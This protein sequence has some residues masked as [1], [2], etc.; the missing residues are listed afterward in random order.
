MGA[1]SL[2]ALQEKDPRKKTAIYLLGKTGMIERSKQRVTSLSQEQEVA[3]MEKGWKFWDYILSLIGRGDAKELSKFVA[4]PER[5]IMNRI[6]TVISCSDQVP[7]WLKT[8][9]GKPLM[10]KRLLDQAAQAKKGR[11]SRKMLSSAVKKGEEAEQDQEAGEEQVRNSA[12]VA[13]NPA[14]SRCRYTVVARQ[15]IENYF[16]PDRDPKGVSGQKCL[17]TA[18]NIKADSAFQPSVF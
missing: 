18:S 10:P 3:A 6:H 14:N 7:V 15:L 1:E 17:S 4:Q 16:D 11:R 5:F 2:A 13:G 9:S 8:D 12:K